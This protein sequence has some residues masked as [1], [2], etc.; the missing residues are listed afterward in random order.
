MA[1]RC[2]QGRGNLDAGRDEIGKRDTLLAQH[3][4]SPRDPGD[5][6]EIV[7]QPGEVTD[8]PLDH[9]ARSSRLIR[10]ADSQKLQRRQDRRERVTKLMS[11]EREE[12]VLSP[13]HLLEFAE[14][15]LQL[16]A[17]PV[18]RRGRDERAGGG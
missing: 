4:R 8:V 18:E 2:H 12:L 11:E 9:V 17:N 16:A 7:D 1:V 13:V 6:Q 3:D 10:G 5:V 14:S 15:A